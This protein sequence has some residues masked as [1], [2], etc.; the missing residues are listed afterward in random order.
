[1]IMYVMF[2]LITL[3]LQLFLFLFDFD[4]VGNF[5]S[6][7]GQIRKIVFDL[8]VTIFYAQSV[9]NPMILLYKM[10]KI[11]TKEEDKL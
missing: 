5:K 11:K 1:M 4:L 6:F 2:A 8:L 10:K 3:P 7:P 9:S